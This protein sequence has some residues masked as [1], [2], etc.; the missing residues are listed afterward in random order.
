MHR[1]IELKCD[2]CGTR[3]TCAPK[4][5]DRVLGR[6]CGGCLEQIPWIQPRGYGKPPSGAVREEQVKRQAEFR[7]PTETV[8]AGEA[9]VNTGAIAEAVNS[10]Q[11]SLDPEGGLKCL[12][13]FWK[14]KISRMVRRESGEFVRQYREE[15]IGFLETYIEPLAHDGTA[16]RQSEF[17]ALC[18]EMSSAPDLSYVAL[19]F[20]CEAP[21][22]IDPT[23]WLEW[24]V[25]NEFDSA[26]CLYC[27]AGFVAVPPFAGG[28][29]TIVDA[30]VHA[31]V[32]SSV[33]RLGNAPK[34]VGI[35]ESFLGL[36]EADYL[37]PRALRRSLAR[38]P[39][40][41]LK[42]PHITTLFSTLEQALRKTCRESQAVLLAEVSRFPW[43]RI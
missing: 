42:P 28:V 23:L 8:P 2:G 30:T 13:R 3:F 17:G 37:S 1:R 4:Q 41:E 38:S 29:P 15:H 10:V 14:S 18:N 20:G 33:L 21:E 26:K 9:S 11:R 27:V 7:P 43:E 35:I 19:R 22:E 31:L 40:Q 32:S 36:T 6:L 34:A 12:P 5:A 24:A 16:A 39:V 25:A